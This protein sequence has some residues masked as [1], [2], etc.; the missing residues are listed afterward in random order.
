[1]TKNFLQPRAYDILQ[2]DFLKLCE[3]IEPADAN[4]QTYS[5]RTF[6]L[7]VRICTEFEQTCRLYLLDQKYHEKTQTSQEGWTIRDYEKI[8]TEYLK[9]RLDNQV[10]FKVWNP[11]IRYVE[12]F[13]DWQ[14]KT[15]LSWYRAY[16]QAKHNRI[17]HFK[18]ANFQNV[19]ISLAGLFLILYHIA[20]KSF[21]VQFGDPNH[22]YSNS[23]KGSSFPGSIFWVR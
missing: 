7:M 3:F 14:G 23:E 21:F 2:N 19:C 18:E 17:E 20:G 13:K 10:G 5:H 4:L 1:M 6:E 16:N 12:P 22:S 15:H 11:E 8:Y 9:S